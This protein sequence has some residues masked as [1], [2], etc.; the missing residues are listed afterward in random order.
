MLEKSVKQYAMEKYAGDESKA[1]EF[2]EGFRSELGKSAALTAGN[3][4]DLGELFAGGTASAL[5]KGV[6]ALTMGVGIAGIS[7]AVSNLRTSSLHTKFLTALSRA[8][9]SN[10]ILR[11]ADKSKVEQYAE[12]V[13]KFAPNVATDPNLLSSILANAVHGEGID[14]MT[15]KTLGD[16]ESRYLDNSNATGFSPKTY[17]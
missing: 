3:L 17:V 9:S 7:R 10:R 13:F 1:S 6:G 11:E 12:T 14:P 4:S 15:I 5:G 8:I 2:I 16:L